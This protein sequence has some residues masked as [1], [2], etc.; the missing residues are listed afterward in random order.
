MIGI[1]FKNIILRRVKLDDLNF[2]P[3]HAYSPFFFFVP[4]LLDK[5]YI[6]SGLDT[7]ELAQSF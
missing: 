5:I 2:I 4:R 6:K 3:N 7:I 1:F